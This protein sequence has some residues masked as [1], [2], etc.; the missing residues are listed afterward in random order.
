MFSY[1]EDRKTIF[2]SVLVRMQSFLTTKETRFFMELR[3]L[4][5]FV[6][7]AEEEHFGRASQ[8]LHVTRPAISQIIA[9]LEAELGTQ[10]FD[11]LAHQVR[12]TPAGKTLL[13]ETRGVLTNLDD[14]IAHVKSAGRGTSGTFV[15]GCAPLALR[16]SHCKAAIKQFRLSY[17]DVTLKL[18]DMPA[19][20]QPKALVEGEIQAG[21]S[22]FGPMGSLGNGRRRRLEKNDSLF[23][24][25]ALDWAVIETGQLGV[26]MPIDHSLACEKR[27]LL[28]DFRGDRFIVLHRS[29]AGLSYE[30][31]FEMCRVAGFEPTIEQEVSTVTSQLNLVS[32]GVGVCLAVTCKKIDYSTNLSVTPLSD[33]EQSVTFIFSWLKGQKNSMLDQMT[34]IIRRVTASEV[35]N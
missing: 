2:T 20:L 32:V 23:G 25:A 1:R 9:A 3:H 6:A 34:Q 4:R 5:Y 11:R 14:A 35:L 26:A 8:R 16:H 31:L 24:A 19:R 27:A 13:S 33:P 21:F 29:T 12:L 15:V 17:P 7:A 28:K 10:L 18:V 22:Y 30:S